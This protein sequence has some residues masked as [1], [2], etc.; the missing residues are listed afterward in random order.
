MGIIFVLGALCFWFIFR[1]TPADNALTLRG[2]AT[3]GLAEYV[4]NNRIDQCV[5]VVANPFTQGEGI[6]QEILAV[7]QAGIRGLEAGFANRV[8]M[9]VVYPELR[10]GA[11]EN[12]RAFPIDPESCTPLSYLVADDAFDNLTEARP[13][14]DLL[15]S[16]IG[17]PLA[18]NQTKCWTNNARMSFALLLPDLHIIGGR[19]KVKEAV[20]NGKLAAF[21][22]AHP[23]S[24]PAE[25]S[26]PGEW[27]KAFEQRFLLV[28]HENI[29]QMIEK[30]PLL[31]P[32]R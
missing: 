26:I 18:L 6:S 25:Q 4:V 32:E 11:R 5:L 7:E 30:Y 19:D 17:V 31:F 9:E 20:I 15:V 14:C 24:P 22:L 16:L 3:R 23:Q 12:P 10:P 27:Q 28:T 21:V 29:D 1:V 2:V 8:P 13:D